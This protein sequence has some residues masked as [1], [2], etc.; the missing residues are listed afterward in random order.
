MMATAVSDQSAGRRPLRVGITALLTVA[1]TLSACS[2][3][4]AAQPTDSPS[5]TSPATSSTIRP[6]STTSPA[7]SSTIRPPSTTS[8]PSTTTAPPASAATQPFSIGVGN[9]G[10]TYDLDGSPPSGPSSF[11]VLDDGSVVIAD[12]MAVERG[13]PRLLRY[14]RFGEL[15]AVIG[16]ASDEVAAIVDVV[17]DGSTLAIL[18]V[19]ASM[20]R[21]RVVTLSIDGTVDSVIEIP[22]GFRF[23]D[24]L[25]GL[26]WADSG[27]LLEFEFGARYARLD[28]TGTIESPV[29]PVFDGLGVELRPQNQR[30]TEVIA[31]DSSFLV[32][33]TTELG[34]VTLVGIAPDGSIVLVVDEVEVDSVITVIRRVQRYSTTGQLETEYVIDAA[35]QYLE[36][37]RPFELDATGKVLYLHARPDRIEIEALDS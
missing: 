10:V 33:R 7:T 26:A 28:A 4:P 15:L 17:T 35:D 32:E 25:T 1:L 21:Y 14:D 27:I 6:P 30:S 9:A 8:L 2:E 37:P 24:G 34:G 16:L 3:S 13:E 11:A 20:N 22:E 12:T 36:I 19:L 23:E 18:D 31:N 5:T 29:V